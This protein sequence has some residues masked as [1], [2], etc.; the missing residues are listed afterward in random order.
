MYYIIKI[1][2]PESSIQKEHLTCVE[3]V[4]TTLYTVDHSRSMGT[5]PRCQGPESN[6][7]EGYDG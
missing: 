2:D 4:L 5:K 7:T 3:S 1:V 6:T